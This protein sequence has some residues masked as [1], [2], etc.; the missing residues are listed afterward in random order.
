MEVSCLSDPRL[1]VKVFAC[2]DWFVVVAL[3]CSIVVCL[4]RKSVCIPVDALISEVGDSVECT[5]YGVV[6][7]PMTAFSDSTL[8]NM[9][10]Y[11]SGRVLSVT[12]RSCFG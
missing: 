4:V 9:W 1:L 8:S 6:P 3:N 7:V 10:G 2:S 11:M 12:I 5:E